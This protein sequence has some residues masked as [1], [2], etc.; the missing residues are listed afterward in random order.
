MG[1][2]SLQQRE[3]QEPIEEVQAE[4]IVERIADDILVT[5]AHHGPVYEG[6]KYPR[7]IRYQLILMK[8]GERIVKKRSLIFDENHGFHEEY[9]WKVIHAGRVMK[10]V[11]EK[12]LGDYDE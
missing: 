9:R 12:W 6:Q 4:E 7:Y 11:R 5:R 1:L 8:S 10:G 3:K 2:E